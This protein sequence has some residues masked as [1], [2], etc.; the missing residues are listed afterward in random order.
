ME[1]VV[2]IEQATPAGSF[3]DDAGTRTPQA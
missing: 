1:L 3:L 2:R